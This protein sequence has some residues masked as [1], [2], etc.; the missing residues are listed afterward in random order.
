MQK[1][2]QQL[3]EPVP[4]N[5]LLEIAEVQISRPPSLS[6]GPPGVDVF[7]ILECIHLY[8]VTL[9]LFWELFIME[10]SHVMPRYSYQEIQ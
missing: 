3:K 1:R 8:I 5:Q 2:W 10:L 4:P 6:T 9:C 7:V